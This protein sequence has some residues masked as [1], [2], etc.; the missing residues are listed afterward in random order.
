MYYPLEDEAHKRILKATLEE[1]PEQTTEEMYGTIRWNASMIKSAIEDILADAVTNHIH[2]A[3]EAYAISKCPFFTVVAKALAF[4][5]E[6]G[7]RPMTEEEVYKY[8]NEIIDER[9]ERIRKCLS[10]AFYG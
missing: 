10:G 6:V 8:A 9:I 3:D 4:R 2:N 1:K 5:L 7:D